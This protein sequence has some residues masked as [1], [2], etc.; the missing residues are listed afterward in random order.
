MS[1]SVPYLSIPAFQDMRFIAAA[2]STRIG[3]VSENPYYSLNLAYHVGDAHE[4]VAE[5]RRRF[6][7]NLGIDVGSLVISQQ[8]HGNRTTV[9]D[10]SH[11]GHGAY[12]HE[13]AISG[14]DAM[15]TESRGVALAVLTADCVPVMVADPVR[16]AIGIA[17]AGWRGALHKIAARAVLKMQDTFGTEPA[18]CL[19]ALGP[20]IGPCCYTAGEDFISQF[21]SA[22]GPAV[23]VAKDR[24]DLQLAVEL[25]LTRVGVEKS[26]ISSSRLCTAC[27]RDLFYSYRAEGGRTGRMMSAI[28]LI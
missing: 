23:C 27:N 20:S 6:C 10:E 7:N 26:N 3:G 19:V 28:M 14:A 2:I 4:S 12:G 24:L 22:F 17:H 5:N 1:P 8:V 18:D 15:I 21:Q 11:K 13:D 9:I 25:Q 16:K